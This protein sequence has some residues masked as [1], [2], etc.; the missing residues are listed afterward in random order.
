MAVYTPLT[1]TDIATHLARFDVGDLQAH[2]GISEGVENTN[3]RVD[4]TK[5]TF[6]LTLFEK[7]VDADA[8]P[9]C[10]GYMQALHAS[11]I[12]TAGVVA[13]TDGAVTTTLAGKIALLSRFLPGHWT[14]QPT[15]AHTAET[16]RLLARMHKT[17]SVFRDRRANTM[18]PSA[19]ISLIHACDT[20]ADEIQTGLS[21]ELEDALQRLQHGIPRGL[22]DGA[23]HADLFPDNVFFDD[24]TQISGVI[25]FWFACRDTLV[26]DLM[27]AFN[28]WCFTPLGDVD[29]A[30]AHALLSAY[31]AERP[32]SPAE[33]A[34][35]PY[36]GMA[37]ATRIVAT[38]LYDYL[39]PVDGALVR[40]KD[41]MEHVR[42]LRH[43][44]D[45][46]DGTTTPGW[47]DAALSA[48]DNA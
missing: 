33:Q 5:G 18:G 44:R 3:Y 43:H 22:P 21:T 26:Y 14:R 1:A 25:D 41:P 23:I 34:A 35:L 40:P 17:G 38:R 13:A 7:R 47:R 45:I 4:T 8:L 46:L 32:L 6:I 24:T 20:R 36:Y 27:L 37:A 9:F 15:P 30:R 19:W 31:V 11:G 28:A 48:G 10:L 16:G 42:I 12:P 2:A 29:D 39:H